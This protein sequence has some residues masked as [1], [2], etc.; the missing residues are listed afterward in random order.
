MLM[1]RAKRVLMSKLVQFTLIFTRIGGSLSPCP[2][3]CDDSQYS[4]SREISA[5][6]C[7][8]YIKEFQ[9]VFGRQMEQEFNLVLSPHCSYHAMD[10]IAHRPATRDEARA[11]VLALGSKLS[12]AIDADPKLSLYFNKLSLTPSEAGVHVVFRDKEGRE[13]GDGCIAS[14]SLGCARSRLDSIQGRFLRY[15]TASWYTDYPTKYKER[16]DWMFEEA[17]DEAI[18]LNEVAGIVCPSLHQPA[19]FEKDLDRILNAFK[20]E[21]KKHSVAYLASGWM[22]FGQP[23]LDLSEIRVQCRYPYPVNCREAREILLL[24]LERLLSAFN[25]DE[26]IRPYLK[27]Y[28]LAVSGVELQLLFRKREPWGG[29]Y[30]AYT[31]GSMESAVLY[32]G[33]ITYNQRVPS[34]I[35]PRLYDTI[36]Y[37]TET[38]PEAKR[39]LENTPFTLSETVGRVVKKLSRHL[40]YILSW[41][42]LMFV[43]RVS[44]LWLN[45]FWLLPVVFIVFIYRRFKV[46]TRTVQAGKH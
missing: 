40:Q 16:A 39:I 43:W 26:E 42:F 10:F 4:L 1:T 44:F 30:S 35:S 12:N 32:A 25:E 41:I 45:F 34:K 7:K 5:K 18:R 15:R 27:Q 22:V 2:A 13:Y 21:M 6:E 20:Q 11:L 28:P 17:F 23:A 19:P 8:R 29:G 37:A 9:S 33:T 31:D 36:V 3:F 38:Y 24:T 14:V 46:K